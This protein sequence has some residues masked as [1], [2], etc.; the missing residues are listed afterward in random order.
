MEPISEEVSSL[1]KKIQQVAEDYSD[2]KDIFLDD[3]TTELLEDSVST[4]KLL[5]NSRRAFSLLKFKFFLKGL[6]YQNVNKES[7]SKLIEYVDNQD[8]AEFI[9]NS[10]NKIIASNSK[11]SCCLMGLLLN[12]MIEKK[13]EISQIDLML[14]QVLPILNDFDLKNFY[15]LY[16]M[17][18]NKNGKNHNIS[19][20]VI[21]ESAKMCETEKSN[22]MLTINILEKYNFIDKDADVSLDIDSKDIDFSSVDY[23][24]SLYF[25]KLSE[26]LYEYTHVLF[27]D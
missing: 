19:D 1:F 26:K 8:K 21:S 14:L 13:K 25:N 9:T 7:I 12:E 15:Y 27:G 22:M 10:F 4:L 3:Q 2:I 20:K 6:N 18:Q 16:K 23:D 11:Y 5:N 24:E 17:Q